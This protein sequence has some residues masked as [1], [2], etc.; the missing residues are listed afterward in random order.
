[1]LNTEIEEDYINKHAC[2]VNMLRVIDY[3][4]Q[5]FYDGST[6]TWMKPIYD[7]LIQDD[8]PLSVRILLTKIILNRP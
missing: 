4:Y 7:E 5:Q 8:I 1:M 6:P 3:M 2:M